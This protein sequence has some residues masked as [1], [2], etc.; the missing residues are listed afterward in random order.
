MT[1]TF[2]A[3]LFSLAVSTSAMA[4]SFISGSIGFNGT[5]VVDNPSNFAASTTI[6]SYTDTT[7]A[8]GSMSGAYAGILATTPVTFAAP[9]QYN[10]AVVPAGNLWSFSSAG[11]IY[12]FDPST[13]VSAYTAITNTWS[14][15]GAGTASISGGDFL[16]TPGTYTLTL[17]NTGAA[18]SFA[19]TT[20]VV[21]PGVPD[22]GVTAI[23][24]GFGFVAMGLLGRRIRKI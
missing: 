9:L 18:F 19:A 2:T 13:M 22:G 14:V 15:A 4:A 20:S 16:A 10:P 1:K 11:L 5:P 6:T 8:G 7:V 17:T 3:A 23:L 21:P 12:S 24:L